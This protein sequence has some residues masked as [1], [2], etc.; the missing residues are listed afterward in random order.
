MSTVTITISNDGTCSVRFD[1][2][3]KKNGQEFRQEAAALCLHTL[4][5]VYGESTKKGPTLERRAEKAAKRG[6][7]Q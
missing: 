6:K 5:A 2:P 1:P 4:H 3:A 7:G